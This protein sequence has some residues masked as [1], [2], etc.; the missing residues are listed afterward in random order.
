MDNRQKNKININSKTEW[1]SQQVERIRAV[2]LGSNNEIVHT[3]S[4]IPSIETLNI[5][6]ESQYKRVGRPK[7]SLNKKTIRK[8]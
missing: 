8:N 1:N 7:G 4:N 6:S 5:E 3:N 2:P